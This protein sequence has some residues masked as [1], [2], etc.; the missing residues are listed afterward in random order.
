VSPTTLQGFFER[1]VS[2]AVATLFGFLVD[3]QG[4]WRRLWIA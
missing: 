3:R 1:D 2:D 4:L